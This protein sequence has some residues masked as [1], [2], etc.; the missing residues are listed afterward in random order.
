MSESQDVIDPNEVVIDFSKDESIPFYFQEYALK[1]QKFEDQMDLI[2][3]GDFSFRLNGDSAI[4]YVKRPDGDQV[5]ILKAKWNLLAQFTTVNNCFDLVW[6]WAIQ[7]E[8]NQKLSLK[9][10]DVFKKTPGLEYLSNARIMCDDPM[11]INIVKAYCTHHLELD[12]VTEFSNESG[13]YAIF[14]FTDLEWLDPMD[15]D[16]VGADLDNSDS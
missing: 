15:L 12:Y 3:S 5:D 2:A 8:T 13:Y 4:F 9:M 7:S 11:F 10:K 1:S 16:M 14:G 6:A